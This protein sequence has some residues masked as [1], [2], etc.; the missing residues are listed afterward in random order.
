MIYLDLI[1]NVLR[2][3]REN[4]VSTFSETDYSKMVGDLINDAKT[5]VELSHEWT[6]L[7]QTITVPTVV[8]QTNYVLTGAYQDAVLKE[9][10]Y[11]TQN[12]YLHPKTRHY[13]NEQNY[14]GTAPNSAPD[15]FTWNGTDA[16]GQLQVQVY[17]TPD[18][19]YQL[20]WDMVIPQATLSADATFLKIPSNPVVQLGYAMALR[21]RGETG[22][23]S[24]AEQ[25]GVASIALSDAIQLDANKYQ[26]ELTFVAV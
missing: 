7:R 6:A 22:G 15:C 2:R 4:T 17:P 12:V 21:E 5:T 9:A 26:N 16:T 14:I 25:F 23:Q 13:F 11:D 8:G 1:N 18:K 20:R 19:I 10:L 24:A 3:L